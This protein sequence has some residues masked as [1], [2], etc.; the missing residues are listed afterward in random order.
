MSDEGEFLR[1]Q[2][3]AA[4][5]RL[6]GT[7]RSLGDDLI[8]PLQLRG[9]VRKRPW[10]S[11]GAALLGGFLA[12]GLFGKRRVAS[13][14]P[15][16]LGPVR[17]VLASVRRQTWRVVRGAFVGAFVAESAGMAQPSDPSGVA[18]PTLTPTPAADEV[19]SP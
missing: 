18:A 6:R 17:T 16:V 12:G 19:A 15:A 4:L 9:I 1:Q 5:A 2:A 8:E 11:L 10:W 3:A 13:P 7:L 14:S